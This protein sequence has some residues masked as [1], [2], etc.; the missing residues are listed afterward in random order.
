MPRARLLASLT[1]VAAL[2]LALAGG[3]LLVRAS[4]GMP[5]APE[6]LDAGLPV[7][8]EPDATLGWRNQAGT[9]TWP[10]RLRDRDR[11]IALTFWPGGLRATAPEPPAGRPEVVLIGCSYT[12]GWAVTDAE[13][14]AWRLQQRF[15]ELGFWNLGTAG[16]GTYQSLLALERFLPAQRE[17]AALVLYGLI[18]HHEVRNV[19]PAGWLRALRTVSASG[20]LAVPFATLDAGG[21]LERHPP[22]SA[23]RW[24]L[25]DRLATVAFLEA[26]VDDG[27]SAARLAQRRAVAEALLGQMR[28]ASAAHGAPLLVAILEAGPEA[29]RHYRQW[30]PSHGIRV[31]DCANP[32]ALDPAYQ[33]QGYGHPGREVHAGWANCIAPALESLRV[34]DRAEAGTAAP[35]AAR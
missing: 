13:T 9:V 5:R 2:G 30:L 4:V 8:H 18:E 27:R 23:S 28:D 20:P 24:P 1:T 16:Y 25:D 3:E 15:P 19:A 7:L 6:P 33:V 35:R 14:F 31:V 34:T 11:P 17:P 21:R 10:G 22:Q 26:R 32:H 29:R 12:Q